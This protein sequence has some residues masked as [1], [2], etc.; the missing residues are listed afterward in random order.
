MPTLAD[1]RTPTS[2]KILLIGDSGSGKTGSL[3]AL[4]NEGFE[5]FIQDYD[6]GMDPLFTYVKP[7]CRDRV[8][9]VT[10]QDQIRQGPIG[11]FVVKA[12]AITRGIALLNEWKDE[13]KS[14]GSI[15]TWGTDRI[16]VFDSLTMMGNSSLRREIAI[17][18]KNFFKPVTE[19]G[20]ADPREIIGDAANVLEA[21]FGMLFDERVKC[22]V[23]LIS[24]VRDLASGG[25]MAGFPSAVGATLPRV[26]GR[27]FNTLLV[28]RKMGNNRLIYSEDSHVTT[29]CPVKVPVTMSLDKGLSTVI[30][31]IMSADSGADKVSAPTS[32]TTSGTNK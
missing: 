15:Y 26:L 16:L 4:A 31:A 9:Y 19:K 23:I 5:L 22:H 10:L 30:R 8:H 21:L 14:Y 20:F 3:A 24:H 6:N 27:Y 25:A 29:K 18:G 17:R 2:A 11:P 1:K 13:D 32:A 28:A 12:D 7:E